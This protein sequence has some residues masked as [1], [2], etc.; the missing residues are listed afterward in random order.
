MFPFQMPSVRGVAVRWR[1]QH[2]H[3]G[4]VLGWRRLGGK[5]RR[6]EASYWNGLS[7]LRDWFNGILL[8]IETNMPETVAYIAWRIWA[9]RNAARV[10][11]PSLP[12]SQI[13]NDALERLNEFQAA[14]T[15]SPLI[16][17]A[18]H[19]SHWLPPP[20]LQLKANYDGAIFNN[21]DCAGLGIV[22]RNSEGWWLQLY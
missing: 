12:L 17:T 6:A 16:A 4:V 18:S 14:T 20:L 19:P 7:T 15:P 13:C 10:G 3:Y 8:Q 5:L 21:L 22:I 9:N 11:N 1:T 2:M